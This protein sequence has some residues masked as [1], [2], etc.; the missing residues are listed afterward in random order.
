MLRKSMKEINLYKSPLKSL[1]LLFLSSVFVFPSIWFIITEKE[2]EKIFWFSLCFFGIGFVLSLFNILDRRAQIVISK[3][4]IWDR[5]LRQEM[6]KWECVKDAYEIQIYR[7]FFIALKTDES[8]VSK[9]KL[10]KW[11]KY[12]NNAVGAQEVNINISNI[13]VDTDKFVTF[14]NIMKSENVENREQIIAMYED[15]IKQKH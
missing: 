15:R 6:I 1:R 4:G 14:I 10:Y 9:K 11:A 7:Q 12:L 13:K 3:I 8:F 2:T 5:S